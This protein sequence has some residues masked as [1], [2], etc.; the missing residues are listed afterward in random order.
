M[1]ETVAALFESVVP[2][3]LQ[4]PAQ[5]IAADAQVLIMVLAGSLYHSVVLGESETS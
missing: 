3:R 1:L 4:E 5:V 2:R